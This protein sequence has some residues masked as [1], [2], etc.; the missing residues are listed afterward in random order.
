MLLFSTDTYMLFAYVV[1]RGKKHYLCLTKLAFDDFGLSDQK[2][3][4]SL[5]S[6][7]LLLFC[8]SSTHVTLGHTVLDSKLII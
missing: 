4:L 6:F 3:C 2:R 1:H 5:F 7:L 8:Y